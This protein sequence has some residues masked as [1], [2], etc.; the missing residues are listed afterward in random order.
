MPRGG[1]PRGDPRCPPPPPDEPAAPPGVE[2]PAEA[3]PSTDTLRLDLD[4]SVGSFRIEPGRPGEPI[5]VEADYDARAFEL[6]ESF[7]AETN[8]YRIS[9]DSK[10]G[11][12]GLF[13]R[14]VDSDTRVRVTVPPDRPV[15]EVMM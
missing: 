6:E 1:G 3:P 5:R 7:D 12:F 4:L 8:T 13:G 10:G 11:F 9:F 14:R 2:L 15:V